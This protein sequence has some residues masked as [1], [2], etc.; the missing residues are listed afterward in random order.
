MAIINWY[1]LS[2]FQILLGCSQRIWKAIRLWPFLLDDPTCVINHAAHTDFSHPVNPPS[3]QKKTLGYFR[4][5]FSAQQVWWTKCKASFPSGKPLM[6][7]EISSKNVS[8][9]PYFSTTATPSTVNPWNHGLKVLFGLIRAQIRGG[10]QILF[11]LGDL[12]LHKPRASTRCEKIRTKMRWSR[13]LV[14][15][16]KSIYIQY[17]SR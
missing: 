12:I 1:I 3:L 7:M 17:I 6:S 15:W 2:P 8:N 4:N 14:T 11:Q 9:S 10:Q 16:Q 5:L 13:I